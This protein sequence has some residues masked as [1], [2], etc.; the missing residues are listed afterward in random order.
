[1]PDGEGRPSRPR[2]A[3]YL[4]VSAFLATVALVLCAYGAALVSGPD[5]DGLTSWIDP[6][7][8]ISCC[9]GTVLLVVAAALGAWTWSKSARQRR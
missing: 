5:Y 3:T 8:L 4:A 6:V 2:T 9:D 7:A 1:M